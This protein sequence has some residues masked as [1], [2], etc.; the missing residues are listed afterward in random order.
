M[1]EFLRIVWRR[2][3]ASHRLVG[4]YDHEKDKDWEGE[5]KLWEKDLHRIV[6]HLF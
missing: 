1:K 4:D 5:Q 2:G 3:R 6:E